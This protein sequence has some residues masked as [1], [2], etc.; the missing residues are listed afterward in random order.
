VPVVIALNRFSSDTPA[1]LELVTKKAVEY[2]A[3]KAII[4][5]H[6]AEGGRG[7][8]DL[9]RAVADACSQPS[10]FKFALLFQANNRFC[11]H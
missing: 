8:V 4:A 9:A 7:A 1:E 2:G 11:P 6:W 10:H 3:F 5:N